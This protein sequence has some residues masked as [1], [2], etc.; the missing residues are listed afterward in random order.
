MEKL[1]YLSES[2][3]LKYEKFLIGCD[4]LEEIEKWDKESLGEMDAYYSNDILC[5]IL[6]LIAADGDFT[7]EETQYLNEIFGFDYTTDE[8]TSLYD[9]CKD[10]IEALFDDGIDKGVSMMRGVNEKLADAYKD[11]L[12][13]ACDVIIESDGVIDRAEIDL[14]R[15]LKEDISMK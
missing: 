5:V 6:R 3:K 1:D 13:T 7:E 4:S 9:D 8:I 15:Q 10:A 2:F 14:A 12:L 11:M